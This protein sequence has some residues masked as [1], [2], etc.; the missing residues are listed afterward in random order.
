MYGLMKRNGNGICRSVWDDFER[1]EKRMQNVFQD[2]FFNDYNTARFP[3]ID[4]IEEPN[5]YIIYAALPGFNKEEI[6]IDYIDNRITINGSSENK[7]EVEEREGRKVL[8]KEIARRNFSRTIPL[9]ESCD[10]E[11][12]K[13]KFD[14]GELKIEIPKLKEKVVET[15]KILIE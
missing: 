3:K 8:V 2:P 14:S 6:N 5:K 1:L 15:K 4:I 11:K 10:F 9:E 13:A 12:I 7:A